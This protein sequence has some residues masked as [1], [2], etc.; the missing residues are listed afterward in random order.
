[1]KIA[2]LDDYQQVVQRLP[3]FGLLRDHQVSIFS[4][5]PASLD[6]Q[7]ERLQDMEALVLIRERTEITESLLARLPRLKL[8]S[9]TGRISQHIDVAACQ[10]HNITIAEGVGSPVAPAELCWTLVM[11][12]SRHL[13]PYVRNLHAGQW[14]QA[15]ELGVGRTLAGLTFG[16][17]GYGRIGQRVAQYARAFGMQVLV[18]GS[19][20]S[21]DRAEADGFAAASS[22]SDFFARSDIVSLHLRLH[23]TTRACVEFAD[24]QQM[25]SDA[26]LVN[27]SRAE[28]IETGALL[29]SLNTGRPGFA[30][31]DVFETEPL[32]ADSALL[33]LPNVLCAPHLGYV[34]QNSYELYFRAAFENI[35]RYSLSACASK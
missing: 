10:R 30:A 35:V 21:R 11:A 15:G 32:P 23:D 12:A 13:V 22:K 14:Q 24:L 20:T 28:L 3:C 16:I 34:E 17:W 26:L 8:I 27:T 33:S 31:L 29:R 5:S 4:T 19:E 18:W 2:I 1:M 7:V 9:Q 25:K 6:E